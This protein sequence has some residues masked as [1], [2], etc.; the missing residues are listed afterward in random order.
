M[1]TTLV[2][3]GKSLKIN[4]PF[5]DYIDDHI[6]LHVKT[7][8]NKIFIDKNDINLFDILQKTI[9]ESEQL[10]IV[11][12][13]DNFNLIGKVISTLSEDVLELKNNMLIPSKVSLYKNNSYLIEY[14]GIYINVLQANEN[15]YL[16]EILLTCK[17]ESTTFSLI[18]LDEDSTKILLNP[19]AD[20]HEVKLTS[21]ALIEGWSFIE[22]KTN[23]YGNLENF[24]KSVKALFPE[25]FIKNQN[26]LEHIISSL[27]DANK[28]VTVA[29]SCSGGQIASMLTNISGSS[30]VFNGSIVSYSNHIK[31]AW[32]GVSSDTF[33]SYGAVSELCIREMMEGALKASSADFAMAT[34]GIAGPNG[35]TQSKPVGTVFVGARAKEGNILVERLLLEGD[36]SYI[37][38]QSCY[39]AIKLLLHAGS[40]VFFKK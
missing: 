19:L 12:S 37:Q 26:V 17:E 32:L 36:R 29:E 16:P 40:D 25:K 20:T 14:N 18:G 1:A 38:K 8:S 3:I 23:K 35:G 24:L 2:I 13:K 10:L 27:K 11:A 39:H 9:R 4:K 34:S 21:T 22:A 6:S 28:S 5:L 7:P 30:E 15:E 33:E 31:Q